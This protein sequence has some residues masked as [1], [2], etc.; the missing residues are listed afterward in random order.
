VLTGIVQQD[1]NDLLNTAAPCGVKRS[2][3]IGVWDKLDAGAVVQLLPGMWGMFR[4]RWVRVVEA[5][6]CVIDVAGHG[7]VNGALVIVPVKGKAAVARGMPVLGDL[8][9]FLESIEEVHGIVVGG[10]AYGKLIHDQGKA[11][12]P[13]VMLPEAG[14]EWAGV[15]PMGKE[16]ALEVFVG[17]A[18]GLWEAIHAFS[19]FHIDMAIVDKVMELVVVHD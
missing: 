2:S 15:V 3:G 14:S 8:V 10:V 1:A 6:Q 11:H 16:E 18:A 17:D 12:I 9:L 4:V 5:L 19:D 13:G 7:Q